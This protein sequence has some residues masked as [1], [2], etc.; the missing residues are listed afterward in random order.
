MIEPHAGYPAGLPRLT[1]LDLTGK[2][3]GPRCVLRLRTNMECY[4]DQA[5]IAVRDARA[6]ASLGSDNASR[7]AGGTW[8]SRLHARS[9]TRRPSPVALRLRLRRPCAFGLD[10][11]QA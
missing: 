7:C 6:E 3:T 9:L 1:T 11:G 5:F 2:L 4:W 10:G 8:P